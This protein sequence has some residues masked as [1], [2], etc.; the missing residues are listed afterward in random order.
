VTKREIGALVYRVIGIYVLIKAAVDAPREVSAPVLLRGGLG[1]WLSPGWLFFANVGSFAAQVIIGLLLWYSAE[2]LASV[3]FRS[4]DDGDTVS[5]RDFA[6]VGFSAVGAYI[7][8]FTL[9]GFVS[10]LGYSHWN[11]PP[12]SESGPLGLLQPFTSTRF[13]ELLDILAL[14]VPKFIFGS[15]LVFGARGIVDYLN[16]RALFGDGQVRAVHSKAE[17]TPTAPEE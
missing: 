1:G 7:L 16:K 9:P 12:G 8:A 11:A 17:P 13:P 2:W 6:I 15:W 4:T 3:V 10:E 5:A 14:Y